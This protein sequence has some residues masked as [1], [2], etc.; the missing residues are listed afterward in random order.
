MTY[1]I[2]DSC[3]G[4]KDAS[5]V[6]VCPVDCIIATDEDAMMFIN[7]AECIDCGACKPECPVDAIF[8]EDDVPAHQ[9]DWTPLNI[10]YFA[11]ERGQ[12]LEKYGAMIEAAKEK[13]RD[14]EH[15]N[16]ALY[17]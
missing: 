17:R 7:P 15:A 4:V 16:P 1:I 14:S 10:D 12:F 5:C 9:R 6:A 13:H 11:V 2:T 3:V 8:A